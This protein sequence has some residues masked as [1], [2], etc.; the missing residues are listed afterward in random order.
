[1]AKATLVCHV[2]H[3]IFRREEMVKYAT[4]NAK[5]AYWYC[6]DCL[7]EVQENEWFANEICRIF[8]T[9]RPGQQI[10]TE[11]KKLKEKYGYT[12][13]T[14]INCLNYVYEVEKIKK[15]KSTLYFVNP[16]NVEKMAQYNRTKENVGNSIAQAAKSEYK[17][18]IVPI[19]E[20]K[21][22]EK[23]Q[24]DFDSFFDD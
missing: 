23:P 21:K 6:P 22:K 14:I 17:E 5:T 12:D 2:C 7:K 19:K 3:L 1:M 11:R 4:L 24:F 15:L 18:Y 10:Y 8:G 13:K 20:D 16:T 9:K